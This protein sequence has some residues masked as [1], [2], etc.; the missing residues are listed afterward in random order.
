[1]ITHVTEKETRLAYLLREMTEALDRTTKERDA[2]RLA[3]RLAKDAMELELTHGP[4][5]KECHTAIAALTEAGI[6]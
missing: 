4:L 2:L 3:A 1:M 5:I 6:E